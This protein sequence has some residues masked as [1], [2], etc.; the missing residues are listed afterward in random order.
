MLRFDVTAEEGTVARV[1]PVDRS[2]YVLPLDR[3]HSA[4]EGSICVDAQTLTQLA[5]TCTARLGR[6]AARNAVAAPQQG[7]LPS[8][9][10]DARKPARHCRA[11]LSSQKEQPNQ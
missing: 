10:T 8:I 6:M 4:V 2:A 5:S 3:F 11:G 9:A 7:S 1:K